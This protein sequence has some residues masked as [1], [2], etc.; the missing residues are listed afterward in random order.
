MWISPSPSRVGLSRTTVI[1]RARGSHR[2]R[3]LSTHR[4]LED[5]AGLDPPTCPLLAVNS[6]CSVAAC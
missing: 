1:R 4:L 2:C 5:L 3:D 6:Q